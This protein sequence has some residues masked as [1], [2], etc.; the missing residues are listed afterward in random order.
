MIGPS[1]S[2]TTEKGLADPNREAD[3]V[4]DRLNVCRFPDAVTRN[5]AP[6]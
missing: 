1:L 6:I 5:V 2:D 3:Y 4:R